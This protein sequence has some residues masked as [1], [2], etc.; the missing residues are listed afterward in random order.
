[1]KELGELPSDKVHD[2][3]SVDKVESIL[4]IDLK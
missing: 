3:L 4:Q 1:M 2:Q